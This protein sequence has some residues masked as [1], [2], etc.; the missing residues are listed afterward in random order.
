MKKITSFAKENR[1]NPTP[2]EKKLKN[3]LLKWRI[4][5]RTQRMYDFYIVDFLIPDRWLIIEIDGGYHAIIKQK[6]Y[7]E[8]RT[9]Y[10]EKKG[11]TVIRFLNDDVFLS[12]EKI[13]IAIYLHPLKP[14]PS[15]KNWRDLYGKSMY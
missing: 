12:P 9:I 10:L 15:P 7:D 8:R 2:A 3:L 1:K 11:F 13:K 5:F 4:K 14:P 6:T